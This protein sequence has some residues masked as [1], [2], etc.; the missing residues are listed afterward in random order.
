VEG[1]FFSETMPS[2]RQ[3]SDIFKEQEEK[4]RSRINLEGNTQ[5]QEINASQLPV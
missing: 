3:W 4:V 2:N 1:D 5:A